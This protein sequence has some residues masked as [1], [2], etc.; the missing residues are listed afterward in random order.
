MIVGMARPDNFQ[1]TDAIKVHGMIESVAVGASPGC[2]GAP[3][4]DREIR[5]LQYGRGIAALLVVLFHY[6]G[7][8]QKYFGAPGFFHLFQAGH[9]GVEFFFLLSGYIIFTSHRNDIGRADRLWS[10]YLKRAVRILP[11]YW[12]VAVPVGIVILTVPGLGTDRNLTLGSFL[13]DLLLVPRDGPITLM[14]AWTLQHEFIFYL[15]FSLVILNR[16]IGFAAIVLWQFTCLAVL[17]FGLLPMNYLLPASKL[18]G[19]YNFGFLFGM[20]IALIDSRVNLKCYRPLLSSLCLLAV[21][22]LLACF[23]VEWRERDLI[24]AYISPAAL[25]MIYYVLY[26]FIILGLLAVE[27]M[28]RRF[29]DTTLGT[30]GAASF[31]LYIVHEPLQSALFKVLLLPSLRTAVTPLT[32]YLISVVLAVLVAVLINKLIER[33][34]L[35]TLRRSLLP[36]SRPP[37]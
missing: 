22:A 5:T 10:F 2:L 13:L 6:E 32:S 14:P 23:G 17:V 12:L 34:A 27:N 33:P 1:L 7:L 20:L 8:P 9:S 26:A 31:V 19:F 36:S 29:L 11:M 25:T 16:Y 15:I 21:V 24:D 35:R 4:A 37:H 28:P 3:A 30:L 18:A